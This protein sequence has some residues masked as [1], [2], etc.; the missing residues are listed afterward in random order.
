MSNMLLNYKELKVLEEFSFDYN[1]KIY[2][3]EIAKKLKMNQKTV[4]NVLNRLEKENILKFSREGRNKYYYLNKFNENIKEIVKIIEINRK[5]RFLE[6]YKKIKDLFN[7]L[8][9][10]TEG[11]GVIFGS[12]A[13][14]EAG[15][16]SDLDIFV[17]GKISDLEDLEKIYNIKINVVK[18]SKDKFNKN[19]PLIKEIIKNHIILKGV[20]E[21]INLIWQA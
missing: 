14:K 19:E 21:F 11:I 1:R 20:E 4:S 9:K 16:K 8:E 18:S 2:G 7:K 6:K 13:R 3:R 10:R 17:S 12:Y 5:I 15:E